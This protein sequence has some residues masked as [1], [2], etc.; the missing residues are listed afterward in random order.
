MA[1][2]PTPTRRGAA[3]AFHPP[4]IP[5]GAG[6]LREGE[7]ES[8]GIA[9]RRAFRQVEEVIA[10]QNIEA[11]WDCCLAVP[12]L[13]LNLG[14]KDI[15]LIFAKYL[16]QLT[17][18][19]LRGHPLSKVA[20]NLQRIAER[21]PDQLQNYISRAWK[22]WIDNTTRQRASKTPSPFISSAATSS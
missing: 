10:D 19:K 20:R 22:I 13:A 11:I 1:I 7:T 8:G 21:D 3:G 17:S 9:L 4:N 6:L 5:R 12:Q 14:R 2:G 16:N 18:V 15:L